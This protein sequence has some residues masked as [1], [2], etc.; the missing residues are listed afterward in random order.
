MTRK[1]YSTR[2]NPGVLSLSELYWKLQHQYLLF[3]DRDYF[4][5]KAGI[6][7]NYLP[8]DITHEA[9]I[10]LKFQ[11]FP[12]NKWKTEDITEDHIFDTIEFLFDKVSKPGKWANF[13]DKNGWQ[14]EDYDEYDDV[15][16]KEEFRIMVNTYLCDYKD[17]YELSGEG[18]ILTI[19]KDG[20]RFIFDA[21][22][23]PYDEVNVD[24][25]VRSAIVK[26]RNR[27]HTI[28]VKKEAIRE[29]ADVFEW[30]KANKLLERV[31]SKKDESDIF[32]IANNFAIRHHNPNQKSGYDRNIWYAWMFHF[33]L[34]TYHAVVRM[35]IKKGKGSA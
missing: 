10:L 5:G 27:S 35:L 9:A 2:H 16:G 30:F 24:S 29:L 13:V 15:K 31:L 6:T 1:Y 21:E 12:I 17:G 28:A 3:R 19:G 8:D 26:W 4:R 11:P 20:L 22:I 14:Y 18:T 23:I 7:K 34:A 33:Y 25:K 32:N